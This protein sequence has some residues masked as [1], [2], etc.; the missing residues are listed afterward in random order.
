M[1]YLKKKIQ[2]VYTVN[3]LSFSKQLSFIL[4][5]KEVAKLSMKGWK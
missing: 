2:H 3:S 4:N 5:M 1:L